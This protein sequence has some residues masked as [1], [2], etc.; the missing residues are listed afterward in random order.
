MHEDCG[1]PLLTP[2]ECQDIFSHLQHHIHSE[3][4]PYPIHHSLLTKG[5]QDRPKRSP[6]LEYIPS[7]RIEVIP[8]A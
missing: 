4:R 3:A 7:L 8:I 6:K 1:L 2:A 5:P